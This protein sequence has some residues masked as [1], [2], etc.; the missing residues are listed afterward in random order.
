M[1]SARAGRL[2]TR[3][4]TTCYDANV[5]LRPLLSRQLSLPGSFMRVA[6]ALQFVFRGQLEAEID[7]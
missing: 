5:D 7:R 6:R 1:Y 3:V 2:V 4:A